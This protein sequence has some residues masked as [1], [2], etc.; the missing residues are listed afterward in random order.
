MEREPKRAWRWSKLAWVLLIAVPLALGAMDV[1][2]LRWCC[3]GSVASWDGPCT[4]ARGLPLPYVVHGGFSSMHYMVWPL[5]WLLAL[6]VYTGLAGAAIALAR[7]WSWR[8]R[9][10]AAAVGLAW[11]GAAPF[12]SLHAVGIVVG[13]YHPLWS[14]DYAGQ[15]HTRLIGPVFFGGSPADCST[16]CPPEGC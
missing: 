15:E 3:A 14:S 13:Y 16:L 6:C 9:Y 1:V 10:K 7:P 5:R 2:S 11:L 4:P 12:V 8:R